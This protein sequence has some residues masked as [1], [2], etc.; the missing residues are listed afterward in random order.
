[1]F[2]IG[3]PLSACLSGAFVRSHGLLH[4]PLWA[5]LG[6][7][8]LGGVESTL[9]SPLA[10][11]NGP[12]VITSPLTSECTVSATPSLSEAS[13]LPSPLET[14]LRRLRSSVNLVRPLASGV[15][16]VPSG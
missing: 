4:D 3:K 11:M 15:G 2:S 12:K 5:P 10:S 9:P 14:T 7:D 13:I 1:M 6:G 16:K 8:Q